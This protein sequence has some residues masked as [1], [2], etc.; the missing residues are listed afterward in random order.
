[1]LALANILLGRRTSMEFLQSMRATFGDNPVEFGREFLGWGEAGDD[2]AVD[3]DRWSALGDRHSTPMARPVALGFAVSPGQKSAAVV[4][5]GRRADGLLHVELKEHEPG[6]AWLAGALKAR[7]DKLG[8]PVW[9]RSGRTPEAEILSG[10]AAA[11]L[12]LEPVKPAAWTAACGEL[13]KVV[14]AGGLRHLGDPRWSGAL[15]AV[16]RRDVGDGAWEWT[17]RGVQGDASPAMAIPVA[18]HGLASGVDYDI[19]RSVF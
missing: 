12:R 19:D 14:E 8:V 7:Q 16:V 1:M 13:G 15:A 5:I 17:W 3:V 4:L 18:L 6:T 9:H 10:L 11:G 2:D